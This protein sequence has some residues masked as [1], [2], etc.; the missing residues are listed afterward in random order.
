MQRISRHTDRLIEWEKAVEQKPDFVVEQQ[1]CSL[2]CAENS[3]T[4]WDYLK[5]VQIIK[6]NFC[7]LHIY[8]WKNPHKPECEHDQ[9]M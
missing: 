3:V 2:V 5:S 7:V 6:T 1:F 4:N 8:F 9:P